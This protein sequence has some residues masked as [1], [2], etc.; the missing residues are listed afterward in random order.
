[1]DFKISFLILGLF[2]NTA[3]SK[4][5]IC[6]VDGKGGYQQSDN[7]CPELQSTESK[8]ECVKGFDRFDCL[9]QLRKGTADF[10]VFFPEDLI[11][12]M[13]TENDILITNELRMSLSDPYKE[14]LVAVVSDASGITTTVD[15]QDKKLCHSGYENNGF[16]SEVVVNFL[17]TLV[18]RPQSCEVNK[19]IPENRILS[20][21]KYFKSACKPGP[22]INDQE[23][24]NILKR[25][26][27]KLCDACSNPLVCSKNDIY[28]GS[29]GSLLCLKDGSGDISWTTYR[30][31]RLQ[32]ELDSKNGSN[33]WN[34]Y[35]FLC[36]DNTVRPLNSR[37]PC[38]WVAQ[39]W[40][41]VAA[42]RKYAGEIQ[43]IVSNITDAQGWNE[44]LFNLLRVVGY[45]VEIYTLDSIEAV[46]S[47]LSQIP[48]YLNANS[49]TGCHP[50]RT[51]KIC[52]T[53]IAS[54][55]KCGWMREAAAV[56]GLE[57][58]IDCLKADNTTHCMEAI[59]NQVADVVIV[60]PD[61][62]N[63]GKHQYNLKTL[64][65]EAV[66]KRGKYL[67]VAVVNSDSKIKKFKDLEGKRACF[68]MY[69]GVSWNTVISEL[70][71]RHLISKCPYEEALANFFGD[72]CVPDIPQNYSSKLGKLCQANTFRG[73]EGALNCL[74]NGIADVAFVSANN[75]KTYALNTGKFNYRILCEQ[76]PCHLSW[77]PASHA[78]VSKNTTTW[79]DTDILDVFLEIDNLF[80]TKFKE[81]TRMFTMYGEFDGKHNVLFNDNTIRLQKTPKLR[82]F[83]DMP[84]EYEELLGQIKPCQESVYS[85]SIQNV[86][87]QL[88]RIRRTS[89]TNKTLPR[90]SVF[91]FYTKCAISIISII[92]LPIV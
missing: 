58:D 6:V 72:S 66:D 71:K 64:F 12:A 73:D 75:L 55:Y 77:S 24:D 45:H 87:S 13:N 31:V 35:K 84:R 14:Q 56:H 4:Y 70:N 39:P 20:S 86:P 63:I 7:Y 51:V 76:E 54:Q 67:T 52:T 25:T 65:Y 62:V 78:M 34:N 53:S 41:V 11:A 44:A 49:F 3:S 81:A 27:K 23:T 29:A 18:V 80:G 43:E 59:Q 88:L 60:H 19:T 10:S 2:I 32:F 33:D 85:N 22:W 69:G 17:E 30:Q 28:Y 26:Y 74:M 5:R 46:D 21:S 92:Y 37:N 8:V 15:M 36:R 91:E 1:M 9:R 83:D 89:R 61:Y 82:N 38:A 90:I 50:P 40:A 68:P 48:G 47:Y 16:V 42:S 57:P 79:R